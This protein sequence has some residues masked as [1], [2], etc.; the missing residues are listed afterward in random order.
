ADHAQ[1]DHELDLLWQLPTSDRVI[2][3]DK[4]APLITREARQA[5]HRTDVPQYGVLGSI[6][7]THSGAK[8]EDPLNTRL[9]VNT[10]APFS[11][12]VCGVQG[13]GKSHTVGVLLE[14]MLIQDDL[15][16]GLLEKPLS[17][18]VLHFGETGGAAQPCEAA[19]QAM[20]D[21]K[22]VRTPNVKV[23]VSPSSVK[24]M[25]QVYKKVFQ[26]KVKVLPLRFTHDE[27][28]AQSFLSMMCV[29]GGAEPPLYVQ[30]I[31]SLLREMGEN[32]SYATFKTLLE[33]K[34]KSFN[35]A[36]KA[37]LEQRMA[38]LEAFLDNYPTGDN[39]FKA[40]QLTIVD[41]TDPFIDPATACSVFEIVTRLFVRSKTDTGKFMVVDEAHKASLSRC[42]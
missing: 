10:N 6:L 11:A 12:V 24:T 2:H 17:G 41:L 40:G 36:Q 13:S 37:G 35:P 3:Q 26:G 27:L 23:Y 31:L 42:G 9:Y 8:V 29:S 21:D 14:S 16:L 33:S 28:D 20:S 32:F 30:I 25:T 39:R 4:T 38:I 7:S 1:R 18:L 19:Y 34:K 22:A 5:G 15:R